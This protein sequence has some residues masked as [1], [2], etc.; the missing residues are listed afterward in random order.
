MILFCTPAYG[1]QVMVPYFE[2]CLNLQES[3]LK[4]GIP[5]DFL[6]TKNESLITRARNTSVSRFLETDFTHLMF[7]DA[8]I[9]FEAE[10]VAKLW[11]L[12][13]DV[14][15]GAYPMK[16]PDKPCSAWV[17]GKLVKLEELNGPTKVDY[18]GTGF[19]MINRDVFVR[20]KEAY[21]ELKH[22]ESIGEC[23]AFFETF[24]W[25]DTYLSEDY[26][27]CQRFRDIGGEIT[28]DPSIK[29]KHWGSFCYA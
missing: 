28:L 9:E 20:L 25:N 15:V 3:L 23:W 18:A 12:D 16:R 2:S 27:F 1:G 26:A 11:N 5:F 6:M 19:M 10:D 24:I 22:T 7:I 13:V 29:L 21:P 14:A 4:A 8:D 17:N